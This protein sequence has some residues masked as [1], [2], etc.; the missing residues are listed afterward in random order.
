MY[1]AVYAVNSRGGWKLNVNDEKRANF[2]VSV[3]QTVNVESICHSYTVPKTQ[4][5]TEI[6]SLS[7]WPV[8][9]PKNYKSS[10][11]FLK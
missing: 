4:S 11:K 5:V 9:E 7:H 1:Y 8:P 10:V 2:A 3:G 6:V